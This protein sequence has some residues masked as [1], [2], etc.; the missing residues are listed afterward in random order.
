MY[1]KSVRNGIFSH[2]NSRIF[3]VVVRVERCWEGGKCMQLVASW[4]LYGFWNWKNSSRFFFFNELKWGITSHIFWMP[5]V[6]IRFLRHTSL[7]C[8]KDVL[9]LGFGVE[10]LSEAVTPGQ[11]GTK[12]RKDLLSIISKWVNT[13][14]LLLNLRMIPIWKPY[15]V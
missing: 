11:K 2:H 15:M 14:I 13:V 1:I 12:R 10:G 3:L 6:S 5:P 8:K 9:S 7:I 4:H